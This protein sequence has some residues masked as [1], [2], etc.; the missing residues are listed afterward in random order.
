MENP[1][2]TIDSRL[3]DRKG[4]MSEKG[5]CYYQC[6][7]SAKLL[8]AFD[9]LHFVLQD[10]ICLVPPP[11]PPHPS[12]LSQSTSFECPVSCIK[13][14]LVIYFKSRTQLSN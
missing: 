13:L 2:Y 8:L 1:E 10:Q 14:A 4:I 12:G 5:V 9:L 6:V 3:G 11:S 7:L